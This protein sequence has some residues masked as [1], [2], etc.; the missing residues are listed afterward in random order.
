MN[1]RELYES[2][3]DDQKKQA[4]LSM[5]KY[6]ISELGAAMMAAGWSPSA[7]MA[8]GWSPSDMRAAG[9][10]PLG[11]ENYEADIKEKATKMGK[12]ESKFVIDTIRAGLM[13]G[14]NYGSANSCGCYLGTAAKA[15]N[16]SVEEFCNLHKIV[17]DY[18]SPAEQWFMSVSV[19]DTPENNYAAKMGVA[20]IEQAIAEMEVNTPIR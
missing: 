17:K 7:M 19:G 4:L 16:L 2:W 6:R 15:A 10:S 3:N 5:P 11:E 20:W 18:R 9:W 14:N 13:D 8:A 1:I 12:E